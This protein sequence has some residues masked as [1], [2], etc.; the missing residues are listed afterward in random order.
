MDLKPGK[1][2]GF[3]DNLKTH[4]KKRNK[5]CRPASGLRITRTLT[6]F[7][8]SHDFIDE[9]FHLSSFV[10]SFAELNQRLYKAGSRNEIFV[11]RL[12]APMVS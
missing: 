11:V 5:S 4:R 6:L 3:S 9:L 8:C 7:V 1:H 2:S 12:L 10:I